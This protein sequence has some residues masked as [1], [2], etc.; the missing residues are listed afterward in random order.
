[1]G[2]TVPTNG[3]CLTKDSWNPKGNYHIL[4]QALRCLGKEVANEA[5]TPSWKQTIHD[6]THSYVKRRCLPLIEF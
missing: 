5:E 1:M 4:I 2:M 3:P 6:K